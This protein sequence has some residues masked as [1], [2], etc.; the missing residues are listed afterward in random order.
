MF[1]LSV[2]ENMIWFRK[3]DFVNIEEEVKVFKE[4]INEYVDKI[5]VFLKV[6]L[7]ILIVSLD[8]FLKEV[9]GILFFF[10]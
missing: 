5:V 1:E 10:M 2:F 6:N 9:I 8:K 3:I 4:I 7:N